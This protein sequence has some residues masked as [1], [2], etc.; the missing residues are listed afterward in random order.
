[1]NTNEH[2]VT[3]MNDVSCD[4]SKIAVREQLLLKVA[5]VLFALASLVLTAIAVI[6]S[7]DAFVGS[8][9]GAAVALVA[10]LAVVNIGIVVAAAITENFE[11]PM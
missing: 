6:F 4:W 3:A 7:V 2:A 5:S 10:A 1:M 8:K 11:A 9:F